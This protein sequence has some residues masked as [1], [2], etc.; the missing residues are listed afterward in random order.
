MNALPIIERELRVRARSR[1]TYW[2]RFAVAL[3]GGVVW[4][5]QLT[6]SGWLGAPGA[7]DRVF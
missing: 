7:W 6:W 1:A 4:L 2:S 3:M 5:P